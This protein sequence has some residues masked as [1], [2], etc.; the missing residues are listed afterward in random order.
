MEINTTATDLELRYSDQEQVY[1]TK[2]FVSLIEANYPAINLVTVNNFFAE[3]FKKD[4]VIYYR[5]IEKVNGLP[6]TS[7]DDVVL[8]LRNFLGA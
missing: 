2:V 8:L 6:P 3:R 4:I 5:D 1:L 7:Y